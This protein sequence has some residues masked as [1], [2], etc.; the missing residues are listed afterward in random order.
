M[1]LNVRNIIKQYFNHELKILA[2]SFL[3]SKSISIV[4]NNIKPKALIEFLFNDYDTRFTL[5]GKQKDNF[6]FITNEEELQ[7][8]FSPYA[9]LSLFSIKTSRNFNSFPEIYTYLEDREQ[10]VI[11]YADK[12]SDEI[13]LQL[14][15][16]K[17]YLGD[18]ILFV[19]HEIT[20]EVSSPNFIRITIQDSAIEN[21]I[22]ERL[23]EFRVSFTI[24]DILHEMNGDIDELGNAIIKLI[25]QKSQSN[26]QLLKELS[27]KVTAGEN[28]QEIEISIE[29]V[30][31][32]HIEEPSFQDIKSNQVK[33]KRNR[34]IS[35]NKNIGKEIT[36]DD[37]KLTERERSIYATLLKKDFISREELSHIVWGEDANTKSNPDAIDQIISRLRRKFVQAGYGKE[38]IKVKKGEGI[39]LG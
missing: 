16:L 34:T 19:F 17:Y 28:L 37:I 32:K 26:P 27:D 2:E 33:T 29:K 20:G 38:Y 5:F 35:D 15:T 3:Q 11:L 18:L 31:T 4:S 8:N 12:I 30:E 36:K 13:K 24:Q 9:F 6:I 7:N 39:V 1:S 22:Q 10:T 25:L 23:D 21:I 14:Y